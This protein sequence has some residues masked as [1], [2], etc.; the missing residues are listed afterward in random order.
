MPETLA[1]GL[2]TTG[3]VGATAFHARGVGDPI[4]LLH[5]VGMNK[6]FWAPQIEDLARGCH[7]IACDLLGHGNSALPPA[8]VGLAAY[9]DA[10]LAVLDRLEIANANVVGH[11]LGALI[12]IDLALRHPQRVSRLVA[13]NPVYRRTPAQRAAVVARA[14]AL[15]K[16]GLG[17]GIDATLA[18][19]FGTDPAPEMRARVDT[20]RRW[21]QAVDPRGYAGAYRIFAT[22]DEACAGRLAALA[23][24]ALFMT[25]GEDPNSTPEMTRRM[26][27]EAPYGEALVV[28]G[29]RHMMS[30]A[31]P[32][33][34]TPLLRAFLM[35]PF[36]GNAAALQPAA[37]L[38]EGDEA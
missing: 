38:T 32:E 13:M 25:G 36:E 18:R 7:V 14:E 26:A 23:M 2:A 1:P 24:P 33:R 6:A 17:D 20:V 27:V 19:W 9:G 30:F 4:V 3:Y 31:A 10:V 22:A 34:V 15:A 11:S 16:A 5:G 8:G 28:A 37:A 29:Q 35:R 12:A 21:L